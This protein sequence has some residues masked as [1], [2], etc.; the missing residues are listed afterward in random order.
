MALREA[1]LKRQRLKNLFKVISLRLLFSIVSFILALYIFALLTEEIIF[2]QHHN[3]DHKVFRF[4]APYTNADV[5]SIMKFFTFFGKPDFLI[6]AYL[7]LIGAF[8]IFGK[9]KYAIETAIIGVS[10]TLLLFG[11]KKLFS[12]ERPDIPVLEDISGYSYPSGHALLSFVFCSLLV[13]LVWNSK[14]RDQW[15]WPLSILLILFSLLIGFSRIILRVHYFT[16]V[17]A[18]FCLGYAWVIIAL[19]AQ[20]RFMKMGS[21]VVASETN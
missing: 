10:S 3:F 21:K 2:D 18:G 17:V 12:R 14:M 19:W 1:F 16:D 8:I 5:I 20:R 9:R 7:F 6:P 4:L 11:L 15:K 13:Y